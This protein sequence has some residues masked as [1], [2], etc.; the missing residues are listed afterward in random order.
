MTLFIP[1][2][3]YGNDLIDVPLCLKETLVICFVLSSFLY[4]YTLPTKSFHQKLLSKFGLK[5]F[6]AKASLNK[7]INVFNVELLILPE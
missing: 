2:M 4:K 7:V 3:N 5:T 1:N 6:K